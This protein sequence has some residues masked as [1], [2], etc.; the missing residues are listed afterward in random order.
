MASDPPPAPPARD[1]A[2]KAPR[3]PRSRRRRIA[4][5]VVLAVALLLVLDQVGVRELSGRDFPQTDP[6]S[7]TLRAHVETLAAPA[8]GGRVPGSEGNVAAARYLADALAA[9]GVKPFP[10]IGGYLAPR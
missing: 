1:P 6:L 4:A 10:S 9:A 3:K 8:W 7:P 2:A 5:L